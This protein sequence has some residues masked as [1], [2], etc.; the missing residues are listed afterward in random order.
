MQP[1]IRGFIKD[2]K[3]EVQ[4]SKFRKYIVTIA[5]LGSAAHNEFIKGE[6]DIDFIVV[7]KKA[8]QKKV[9]AEFIAKTLKKLDKKYSLKLEE[10]CTDRKKY[11]NEILNILIKIESYFFF[12]V[13][14]YVMSLEDYDFLNNKIKNPRIWFLA[15]FLGSLNTFLINIKDTGKTIYGENLLRKI[16]INLTFYDR[17]KIFIE[18]GYV[19]LACFLFFPF[20]RKLA[21]KHAVKASLYQ[22]EFDL[23]F[24]H[25]H[26]RGYIKDAKVFNSVFSENKFFIDHIKKALY[27]R[28]K[29]NK[30]SITYF[31]CAKFIGAT[32]KFIFQTMRNARS[33]GK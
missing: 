14:F 30:I 33:V 22:E 31:E 17:V 2:L 6:S 26:L 7:V 25:K 9:V 27:Y 28:K 3:Y 13:P 23:L 32:V 8:E 16:H 29:Y 19:L 4:I 21:L 1:E 20:D 18:Q 12:G 10:T 11:G 24:L 15:T 5:L